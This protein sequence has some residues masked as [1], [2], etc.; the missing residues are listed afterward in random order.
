MRI[1]GILDE[2]FINY[3]LPSMYICSCVCDF[4]CDRESG[5]DYCQ[6][7]SII[8]ENTIDFP[9]ETII[10]RYLDNDI[11][12]AIV[13]GGLEPFDQSDEII[14]FIDKIRKKYKCN[15]TIVIYSGYEKE[16]IIRYVE[17]LSTYE[18]IIIKYGRFIPGRDPVFDKIL[19]VKL[20]SDNQ[21][22]E[23]IG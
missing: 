6:N 22:S 18:N 7:R 1:K 14:Q 23:K 5:G 17:M 4:K 8:R 13:I 11:T 21:W 16:E 12:K 3:K 10:E 19:G 9:D 15:D 2:D 20:A